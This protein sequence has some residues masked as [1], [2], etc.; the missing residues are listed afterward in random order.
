MK[1]ST[2][3]KLG[4]VG[5]G[6]YLIAQ[7]LKKANVAAE[8]MKRGNTISLNGYDAVA[9]ALG[10][11]NGGSFSE[12][13]AFND[14]LG[15]SLKKK[16]K[17]AA[18]K[19]SAPVKK[20]VKTVQ[21][22]AIKM[23]MKAL[24]KSS[25]I[26]KRDFTKATKP[27]VRDFKK[28]A[29]LMK[30]DFR[31]AGQLFGG[32]KK[33]PSADVSPEGDVEYYDADGNRITQAQYDQLMSE[34]NQSPPLIAPNYSDQQDQPTQT[35]DDFFLMPDDI[36][37]DAVQSDMPS[38]SYDEGETDATYFENNYGTDGAESDVVSAMSYGDNA[39]EAWGSAD[40]DVPYG[41]ADLWMQQLGP[42]GMP[43]DP[44]AP[45]FLPE[46]V[47]DGSLDAFAVQQ[48]SDNSLIMP[49]REPAVPFTGDEY[50]VFYEE[51]ADQSGGGYGYAEPGH[52]AA[53]NYAYAF[54]PSEYDDN[55]GLE[56]LGAVVNR[57][58]KKKMVL[59]NKA[60]MRMSSYGYFLPVPGNKP[61]PIL[62]DRQGS[63]YVA[64]GGGMHRLGCIDDLAG[65][66][67]Y[68][69]AMFS[70][71]VRAKP[72]G[73]PNRSTFG[74][75]KKN[76]G[77]NGWGDF[78]KKAEKV[79]KKVASR[80]TPSGFLYER[81]KKNP[82]LYREYRTVAKQAMPYVMIAG[83][84][85]LSVVSVGAA[86]PAGAAMIAG[87]VASL[88]AQ[89]YGD[90][91]MDHAEKKLDR[92]IEEDRTNEALASMNVIE[93]TQ[94]LQPT[95]GPSAGEIPGGDWPWQ[96]PGDGVVADFLDLADSFA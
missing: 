20:M 35:D 31:K 64:N 77:L 38:M 46:Y 6:A 73:K 43:G 22:V 67:G 42:Y 59:G 55:W 32:K 63:I 48:T 84:T 10:C 66:A 30:T 29:K 50:A 85:A 37:G 47:Q 83:G 96:Y 68:G 76:T 61:M 25:Q 5:F 74:G 2:S 39:R 88:G 24:K 34:A 95:S 21:K 57:T 27:L 41:G 78:F 71:K 86:S 33:A 4:A 80:T 58:T 92:Q 45:Q 8:Q 3:L 14:G 36:P 60:A 23:P 93:D 11:C 87:G 75:Y 69:R 16:L 7:M 28:G 51:E 44:F 1:A 56:G 91:K 9:E 26:V 19:V 62:A 90:V 89:A 40:G 79:S 81:M 15:F 12:E 70:R 52:G 94:N 13:T 72:K 65:V 49:V 53:S 17:K 54:D 82:K 18:K